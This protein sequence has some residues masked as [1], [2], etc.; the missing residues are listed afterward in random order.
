MPD[1]RERNTSDKIKGKGAGRTGPVKKDVRR[2]MTVKMK[3]ELMERQRG[4]DTGG[5]VDTVPEV[6][7]VGQ[8]EETV[9]TTADSLQVHTAD[10]VS[11]SISRHKR[12]QQKKRQRTEQATGGAP[13][14]GTESPP[15][16]VRERM[17]ENAASEIKTRSE[18]DS[19]PAP[20]RE[21]R[22]GA[23]HERPT[24]SSPGPERI[25]AGP[26]PKERMRQAAIKEKRNRT[27]L[28]QRP[29]TVQNTQQADS[30]VRGPAAQ[31][32][33]QER[34]RQKARAELQAPRTKAGRVS[35]PPRQEAPL[36]P[37][38]SAGSTP[39]LLDGKSV[40]PIK[41]RPRR[42]FAPKEKPAGGA[43]IPKTRQ[44]AAKSGAKAASAAAKGKQAA[45]PFHLA[46]RR[47]QRNAQRTL[48]K[49]S[50]KGA[51]AMLDLS[52]KA[53]AVT[54]KAV[55]SLISAIAGLVGGAFLV[56]IICLIILVGA[57]IASPF[58]IL[59]SNEAGSGTVTLREAISQ[60][61]GEYGDK[62]LELQAGDYSSVIIEGGPP[63]W[64]EVAAVFA[65]KTA[66]ADDGVDVATLDNDRVERLRA[67]FWD[68]CAITS[69]VETI[70]HPDSDPDDD[71]DDSWTERILHITVTAKTADEMRTTYNFTDAQNSALTDLL[72]GEY[73]DLWR[74]VLYGGGG[75]IVAIAL[76]QVGNVGGQP[77]WSWYGFNSHVEWCACFVS[78]CANEAGYI[79]AGIIPKFAGCLGGSNWFKD[80]GLWQ[81]NSYVPQ[82]GDIIFFD[83]D[84]P[85]G[86]S[87][88]QDGVPD[89]VGIVERVE[90]GYVYTVEGNSGDA[91]R[92][93]RYPVGYY[94]IFGYATPTY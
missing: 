47:V 93:R 38:H 81:S 89:H 58:G 86:Y 15:P 51:K 82:L 22:P 37:V 53:A 11:K 67:V 3:K 27:D 48:L 73:A 28:R 24:P 46:K 30:P 55:S 76:S 50:Q 68:M 77:Y 44:V 23:A 83:W 88:P 5:A 66:G 29:A 42:S 75:D 20:L 52:R 1:I 40:T 10:A 16:P 19:P 13:S 33:P 41:E 7:A 6:Q 74:T 62:L 2:Q 84:D 43:F 57:I 79:E 14:P 64:R 63:S 54:V 90:G 8:V 65:V 45:Q 69:E 59:F 31:P 32:G 85:S 34:M 87:G 78:W 25:P 72:T 12:K 17:R 80:R 60:I 26:S 36:S 4:R 61:N 9:Y 71:T 21:R 94:E 70:D 49:Q 91:C 18:P 35:S 39:A 92:Q 56:P